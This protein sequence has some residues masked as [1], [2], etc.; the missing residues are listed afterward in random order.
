MP[1][2]ALR[3][4]FENR[5]AGT[6]CT[7]DLPFLNRLYDEIPLF[8][9]G[10]D[11]H[12]FSEAHY[13]EKAKLMGEGRTSD[14]S[15]FMVISEA[16]HPVALRKYRNGPKTGAIM[17]QLW[18]VSPELLATMDMRYCNTLLFT[19]HRQMIRWT[20]LADQ[21]AHRKMT[22]FTEAYMYT[23]RDEHWTDERLAK[24]KLAKDFTSRD[25]APY[26]VYTSA[27]DADNKKWQE[28]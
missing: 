21:H 28:R 20:R 25:G 7:P 10:T 23:G 8:V 2:P 11:K 5:T 9:Y 27:D 1:Q 17:G 3:E 19:R 26:F 18:V 4:F 16:D 15:F 14:Q 12:G 24:L 6:S 13:L 22:H